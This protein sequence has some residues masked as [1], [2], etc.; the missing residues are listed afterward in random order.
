MKTADAS[1]VVL[2]ILDYEE[3][4]ECARKFCAML[5]LLW[6]EDVPALFK[7]LE[8]MFFKKS[9]G[10]L[11]VLEDFLEFDSAII[12]HNKS[13]NDLPDIME[14]LVHEGE[15]KSVMIPDPANLVGGKGYDDRLDRSKKEIA[16]AW[17]EAWEERPKGWLHERFPDFPGEELLN[18]T[19]TAEQCRDKDHELEREFWAMVDEKQKFFG[20]SRGQAILEVSDYIP[21][22]RFDENRLGDHNSRKVVKPVIEMGEWGK[23]R[24]D[25]IDEYDAPPQ[26]DESSFLE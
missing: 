9:V 11:F 24:Q 26:S 17:K 23:E 2:M 14:G 5:D 22:A 18:P 3:E 13:I 21:R 10:R 19:P 8:K 25:E 6:I 15:S 1:G 20:C 7:P 16:R 4:L 12:D